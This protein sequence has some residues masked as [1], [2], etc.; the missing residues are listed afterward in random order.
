MGP[1]RRNRAILVLVP[2]FL[3]LIVVYSLLQRPQQFV[4]IRPQIHTDT[5]TSK[6]EIQPETLPSEQ[7]KK[8]YPDH[9][10]IVPRGQSFFY[11]DEHANR[12]GSF[13]V[14][15]PRKLVE[16]NELRESYWKHAVHHLENTK[17]S[18]EKEENIYVIMITNSRTM[19]TNIP[20]QQ[21]TMFRHFPHYGLYG[22]IADSIGGKEVV[23]VLKDTEPGLREVSKS[24]ETYRILR[25]IRD[26]HA[27]I[28]PEQITLEEIDSLKKFILLPA[29]L[30]AYE[31]NHANYDW[32]VVTDD[33]TTIFARN[34]RE[35][36]SQFD[37][38]KPLYLGSAVQGPNHIFASS[39]SVVVLSKAAMR[40]AFDNTVYQKRSQLKR[41]T[42]NEEG[43]ETKTIEKPSIQDLIHDKYAQLTQNECCG[44]YMLAAYLKNEVGLQLD[45]GKSAT[46]FQGRAITNV[47]LGSLNWCS[48]VASL[49]SQ[50][51]RD[52]ELVAEYEAVKGA[53][54][55]KI[56][57][58][59]IYLDF[60]KPYI[61]KTPQQNWDNGAKD[62]ELEPGKRSKEYPEGHKSFEKCHEVC[63]NHA[64]C[65]MLRYDPYKQYCGLGIS[66]VA[67]GAPILIYD[68]SVDSEKCAK[69]NIQCSPRT[70][71]MPLTSMWIVERIKEMR[72]N[73]ECDSLH[74]DSTA[75]GIEHGALDQTEGW[76]H[77]LRSQY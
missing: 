23:D 60:V 22:N 46:L 3:L 66:N 42:T 41:S 36:L 21:Q 4:I 32:F 54:H 72:R 40:E 64:Q 71:K 26:S 43:T 14:W 8:A 15:R 75:E 49:G 62:I 16:M 5:E 68:T 7:N 47:H 38:R 63:L 73:L 18:D 2:C 11:N 27:S 56:L 59:D 6:R 61:Y 69:H 13:E 29:L 77:R 17:N 45:I 25:A 9:K 48:A 57:Y 70:S 24:F 53:T 33:D 34:L 44:D 50:R 1:R 39:G 52:M 10:L 58:S 76:W 30:K 74:Y 51:P 67:L 35:A 12:L 20:T 37:P 28:G 31:G 65:V 55:E 19:W